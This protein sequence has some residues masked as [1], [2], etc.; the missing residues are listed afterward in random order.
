MQRPAT[1]STT[2]RRRTSSHLPCPSSGVK[3][4]T[5]P[6]SLSNPIPDAMALD[7]QHHVRRKEY[8]MY[9]SIPRLGRRCLGD[10]HDS[11][12]IR[13]RS[14]TQVLG[15]LSVSLTFN[16]WSNER[17]W[18][19]RSRRTFLLLRRSLKSRDCWIWI[20]HHGTSDRIFVDCTYVLCRLSW[21]WR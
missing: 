15:A 21:A 12:S 11:S 14:F 13:V 18:R 4:F 3:G 6:F 9:S 17:S 8:P 5:R 7:R 1:S 16:L 10:L 19:S 2:L 20:R